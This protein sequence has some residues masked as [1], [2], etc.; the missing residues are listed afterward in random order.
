MREDGGYAFPGKRVYEWNSGSGTEA[1]P[2]FEW[3]SGMSLRDWFAGQAMIG[4]MSQSHTGPKDWTK[5]GHGWGE[6]CANDL[7]KHSEVVASSLSKFA[8]QIAD[9]LLKARGVE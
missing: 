6:D 5:M 8:Y 7:N 2:Q 3:N 4:F 1:V 9:A